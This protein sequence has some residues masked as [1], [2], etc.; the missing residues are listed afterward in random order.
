[1]NIH[2]IDVLDVRESLGGGCASFGGM[3]VWF[4]LVWLFVC[5][6]FVC[7]VVADCVVSVIWL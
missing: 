2:C 4:D 6:L 1:V 5:F 7:L 3:L